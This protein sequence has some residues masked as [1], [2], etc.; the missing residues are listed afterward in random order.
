I[1]ILILFLRKSVA[2]P[3]KRLVEASE[4][5]SRGNLE[6]KIIINS[7][8]ELGE[9]SNSFNKMTSALKKSYTLIQNKNEELT[10]I[11]KEL[12]DTQDQLL[13]LGGV[14]HNKNLELANINEEL[15]ISNEGLRTVTE[16]LKQKN[17]DLNEAQ[18]QLIRSEKLAAIGLLSASIS[19]ELKNPLGIM[20]NAVY[21]IKT[22]INKDDP[23]V[24]KHM[25]ILDKEIDISNKIIVDLL[26]FSRAKKPVTM[27]VEANEIIEEALAGMVNLPENIRLI[28][29]LGFNIPKALVDK[30]QIRQVFLN[31][32]SNAYQSM[33]DHGEL[34]IISAYNPENKM[35]EVKFSD[36]G[37]GIT[38]DNLARI[39]DPLFTTKAKGFGLGLSVCKAIIEKHD[40]YIKVESELGKGTIFTVGLPAFI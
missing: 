21:F 5:I 39:F 23:K 26:A 17:K 33:Q 35:L 30:D 9:L 14:I 40:G 3:I 36:T 16:E 24:L 37:S 13:N 34:K 6:H 20:K 15:E 29:E 4:I 25:E 31:I 11:N 28:K 27:P 12:K 19:H 7:K 8:D 18:D 38:Q 22:K 10:S 1:I 2:S 32:I